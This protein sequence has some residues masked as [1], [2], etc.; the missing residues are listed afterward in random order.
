MV[1]FPQRKGP[2]GPIN[3][4]SGG[5]IVPPAGQ[6]DGTE[7]NPLI[8]GITES[9]GTE[10]D[11]GAVGDG[12]FLKRVGGEVIGATPAPG[13]IV[14]PAGQ[15]GGS[16]A[17][18]L[19]VGITESS[20]PTAL[21]I[22]AIADGKFLKRSG[23]DLVGSDIVNSP[24]AG[25]TPIYNA[26]TVL[27]PVG[28]AALPVTGNTDQTITPLASLCGTYFVDQAI[29]GSNKNLTLG[30]AVGATPGLVVSLIM[31]KPTGAFVRVVKNH[32]GTTIFTPPST[33]V[34]YLVD[35]LYDGTSWVNPVYKPW[36]G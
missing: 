21:P 31:S 3:T 9:G 27:Q 29:S 13:G 34:G 33:A 14:P 18:P 5:G 4:D 17:T 25:A 2:N 30:N 8:V 15:I 1:D 36:V 35:V 28:S 23:S 16:T 32:D 22:G 7:E 26:S 6:I 24:F 20:G 11:I 19:V 10:L 12:Q